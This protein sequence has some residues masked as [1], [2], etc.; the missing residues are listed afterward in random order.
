MSA[1][2][3]AKSIFEEIKGLS[4]LIALSPSESTTWLSTIYL[5]ARSWWRQ[6]FWECRG[7]LWP[8]HSHLVIYRNYQTSP[9]IS[10]LALGWLL[11][12]VRLGLII[13]F[14]SLFPTLL[15]NWYT[16]ING[17]IITPSFT[18]QNDWKDWHNSYS[19]EDLL[20]KCLIINLP[21]N[22][23]TNKLDCLI[24]SSCDYSIV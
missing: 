17:F 19:F 1:R 14:S 23:R 22:V 18:Y 10:W 8:E 7:H 15:Y 16:N 4:D 9:D 3:C 21:C 13:Q 2:K 24:F 20:I 5:P 6:E 12:L 11:V